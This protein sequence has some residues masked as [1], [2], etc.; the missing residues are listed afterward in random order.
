MAVYREVAEKI[1]EIYD[2]DWK[3]NMRMKETCI[4]SVEGVISN[5]VNVILL[6]LTVTA[7]GIAGE[8]AIFAGTFGAMRS[9]AGGAHA[10]NHAR[11]ILTYMCVLLISIG[12]AKYCS[13]MQDA[14]VYTICGLSMIMAMIV[15]CRYAAKQK[16]LGERT[17]VYRRKLSKIFIVICIFMTL[18]C[19]LSPYV[20]DYSIKE[21]LQEIV[22][23]QA[24]AL[25]AQSVAL[26]I[27]RDECKEGGAYCKNRINREKRVSALFD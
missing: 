19:I 20:Q 9:Y 21:S 6:I 14:S 12:C 18:I 15:N 3:D 26:W 7:L 25:F 24:F 4:C 13:T 16:R 11:C 17:N 8:A 27:A 5:V 2:F 23:I 22:L 10:K 1:V